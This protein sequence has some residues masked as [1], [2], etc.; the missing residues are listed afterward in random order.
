M[1][2]LRNSREEKREKEQD[3]IKLSSYA[4][5]PTPR[6][7]KRKSKEYLWLFNNYLF[8]IE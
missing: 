8:N 1:L 3:A 5:S 6:Y 4:S 7:K 2:I